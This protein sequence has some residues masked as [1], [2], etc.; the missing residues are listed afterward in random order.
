[1]YEY[2][3][4]PAC[5]KYFS[6]IAWVDQAFKS[7]FNAI[8]YLIHFQVD[9]NCEEFL[10]MHE[11]IHTLSLAGLSVFA[12]LWFEMS[13]ETKWKKYTLYQRFNLNK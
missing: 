1:M 11:H 7:L 5:E 8:D 2:I 4:L 12:P 13:L 10:H 3:V 6:T 9:E